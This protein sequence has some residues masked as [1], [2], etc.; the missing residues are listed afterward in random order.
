MVYFCVFCPI[1]LYSNRCKIK[2][3]LLCAMIVVYC[4]CVCVQVCVCMCVCAVYHDAFHVFVCALKACCIL[5]WFFSADLTH[6]VG[7]KS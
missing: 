2:C 4:V 5:M 6:P 1:L 7:G 3:V